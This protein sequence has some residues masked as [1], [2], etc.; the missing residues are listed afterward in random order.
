MA[1]RLML[2]DDQWDIIKNFLP[3]KKGDRGVTAKDNRNFVE[4]VL[5]VNRTGCPWRDIPKAFGKWHAIYVRYDRWA[6]KG[7][8]ERLFKAVSGD[9]DLEYLMIDG[10]IA[11]VHQHGAAQKKST[12]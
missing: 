5:W 10:S 1:D 12:I 7:I 11:R 6:K 9:A 8:W 3:G 4:A 2:R